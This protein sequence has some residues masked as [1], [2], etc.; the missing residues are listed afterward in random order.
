MNDSKMRKIAGGLFGIA[1]VL[2]VVALM[3]PEQPPDYSGVL[4][5]EAVRNQLPSVEDDDEIQV[6]GDGAV[7][8]RREMAE[9]LNAEYMLRGAQMDSIE[10]FKS[11]FKDPRI[12][13]VTVIS[14]VALVDNYGQGSTDTGTTYAMT[15]E[16]YQKI[17]WD[18]FL[19]GSIDKVAD[20]VYINPAL[21]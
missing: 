18:N 8:I 13:K 6:Y 9:N 5:E 1:V 7:G 4:D 16:T 14:T 17:N 12:K 21:Q 10:I 3:I 2:F 20:Q 11:L 19:T 15:R